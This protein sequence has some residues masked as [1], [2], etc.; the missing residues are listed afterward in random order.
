MM[1][2]EEVFAYGFEWGPIQVTRAGCIERR[3]GKLHRIITVETP[4]E[5]LN[6]YVSPAGKSVRVFRT[7]KGEMKCSA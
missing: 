2:P 7:G 6:I 4:Y 3:A 1:P 5:T